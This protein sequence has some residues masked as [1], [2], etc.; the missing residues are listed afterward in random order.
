M[1]RRLTVGLVVALALVALTA[2][3]VAACLC[4][5]TSADPP[6]QGDVA[7]IGVVADRDDPFFPFGADGVMGYGIHYT[8]AVE[9]VI[10]G[11]PEAFTAI[12]TGRGGGDCGL[13]MAVGERWRIHASWFEGELWSITCSGSELLDSGVPVP[14]VPGRIPPE[15]LAVAGV[16]L[17]IGAV[18][19]VR[20][21][22]SSNQSAA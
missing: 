11:D 1:T 18:V 12:L 9:E 10:K 15:G 20:R 16:A 22:R 14:P 6:I 2:R 21:R 13:P 3:P 7:F 17:G 4:G 19:L 5:S 8:F